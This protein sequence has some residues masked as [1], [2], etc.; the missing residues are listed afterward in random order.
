MAHPISA[1]EKKTSQQ[2]CCSGVCPHTTF[3]PF[4]MASTT[5]RK[6][7]RELV[8]LGVYLGFIM[9]QCHILTCSSAPVNSTEG[10][11]STTAN[12][13]SSN[14]SD[15]TKQNGSS[16][17][18]SGVVSPPESA[19]QAQSPS[20]GSIPAKP[21]S[22]SAP[23]KPESDSA[24][25]KPESDSAPA[26]PE[27]DSAP[28]KP[29]SDSAPAKPKNVSS[30]TPDT[31]PKGSNDGSVPGA[32]PQSTAPSATDTTIVSPTKTATKIN[33]SATS[34][35][36]APPSKSSASP[37]VPTSTD[38]NVPPKRTNIPQS[39]ATSSPRLEAAEDED[40]EEEDYKG[41]YVDD[42]TPD[43][44]G[45]VEDNGTDEEIT[46]GDDDQDNDIT[47]LDA[48]DDDDGDE[49][50][51]M[52]PKLPT[53]PKKFGEQDATIY[54]NP[55]ED[56]HFFVHLVIIA[57]LV[58]IVYITYHNKRK[59]FLLASSRRWKD[60]LCSRGGVEYRRLDQNVNEAM[61]SLKMTNDYIF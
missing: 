55:D 31:T 30:E 24:P 46:L 2:S 28:A 38:V 22:D 12:V 43:T 47:N 13:P 3:V 58:A 48:D 4:K 33:G 34:T 19:S 27:S 50:D 40:D 44:R 10:S 42:P 60:G 51:K 17:G 36:A 26:K 20:V 18:Q 59:I 1:S 54:T 35:M 9:L 7:G 39:K 29:E 61:P 15:E 32:Q 49:Y 56:T 11:R 25:A 16:N 45:G 23:A 37:T 14:Q 5:S 53:I 41:E 21:E 8:L 57:F 6:M 52:M